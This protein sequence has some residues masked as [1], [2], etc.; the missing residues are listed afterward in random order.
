MKYAALVAGAALFLTANAFS[1][2]ILS[3]EDFAKVQTQYQKVGT[4]SSTGQTAPK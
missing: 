3:K 2:E 4:I 1:A